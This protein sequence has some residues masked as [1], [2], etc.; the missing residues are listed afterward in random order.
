M[1]EKM[2]W[3]IVYRAGWREGKKPGMKRER[4]RTRKGID[5]K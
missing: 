5:I 3:V 4:E 1:E 2:K